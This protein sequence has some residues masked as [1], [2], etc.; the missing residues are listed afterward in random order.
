MNAKCLAQCLVHNKSL[1][2]IIFLKMHTFQRAPVVT[3]PHT[4]WEERGVYHALPMVYPKHLLHGEHELHL[5]TEFM[6]ESTDVS[7]PRLGANCK[8]P[9]PLASLNLQSNPSPKVPIEVLNFLC[10][11][12]ASKNRKEI[13]IIYFQV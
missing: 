7:E 11:L 9:V 13:V 3:V 1:T 10:F 2:N 4:S 8:P 5:H 6:L 12:I